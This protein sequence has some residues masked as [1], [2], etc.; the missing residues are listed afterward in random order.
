M[1]DCRCRACREYDVEYD[2]DCRCRACR[3]C[4]CRAC[5][6]C[7]ACG[8]YDVEDVDCR[9]IACREYDVEDVD[10]EHVERVES[11]RHPTSNVIV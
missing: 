2:V 7:G 6:T 10:V 5:R 4:R 8:E 9:C 1:S 3:G 11:I